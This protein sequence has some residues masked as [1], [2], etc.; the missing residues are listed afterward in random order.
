MGLLPDWDIFSRPT[1]A[2]LVCR[3]QRLETIP[4]QCL[5]FLTTSKS[6]FR[7]SQR[8]QTHLKKRRLLVSSLVPRPVPKFLIYLDHFI[9]EPKKTAELEPVPHIEASI[10]KTV[11]ALVR[12]GTALLR[13]RA[14]GATGIRPV[15]LSG[16]TVPGGRNVQVKREKNNDK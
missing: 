1:L 3:I 13:P 11:T 10:L 2:S 16:G 9:K 5:S 4:S 12:H 7:I 14:W 6:S 8:A 15:R